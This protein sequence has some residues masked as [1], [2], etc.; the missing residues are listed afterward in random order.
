MK[1]MSHCRATRRCCRFLR[2]G[3]Q[4]VGERA[5][6]A[7]GLEVSAIALGDEVLRDAVAHHADADESDCVGHGCL[8]VWQHASRRRAVAPA[9]TGD[10]ARVARGD[11]GTTSLIGRGALN[12]AA[13]ASAKIERPTRSPCRSG[14][15][16][17]RG[18][19]DQ[20]VLAGFE[21]E[22]QHAAAMRVVRA[23]CTGRSLPGRGRLRRRQLP[24]VGRTPAA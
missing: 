8:L 24:P 13:A 7:V 19:F 4:Q 3:G 6:V 22:Q 5:A 18:S 23:R 10:Q 2:A 12:Q 1:T 20:R 14:A 11:V 17:R 15:A 21:A 9:A 16:R